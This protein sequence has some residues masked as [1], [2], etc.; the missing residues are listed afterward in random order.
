M[1]AILLGHELFHRLH[2]CLI[3]Y[4]AVYRANSSTLGFFVKA[5]AFGAFIGNDVIRIVAD[6]CVFNVR[7]QC[8]TIEQGE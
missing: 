1:Q 8:G 2:I 3:R 4:A 7:I 6:R 5:L